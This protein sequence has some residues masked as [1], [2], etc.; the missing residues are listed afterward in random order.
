MS[1]G[2]DIMRSALIDLSNNSLRKLRKI[3]NL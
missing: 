3:Y 1:V 2:C